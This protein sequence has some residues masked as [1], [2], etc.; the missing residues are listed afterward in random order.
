MKFKRTITVILAAVMIIALASCNTAGSQYSDK[1]AY[2]SIY[3]YGNNNK[4]LL[5]SEAIRVAPIDETELVE[6]TT[7]GGL[8]TEEYARQLYRLTPTPMYALELAVRA[9]D[10]NAELPQVIVSQFNGEVEYTL[11]T[12]M[13]N[14]AG[15]AS[16]S[17][18]IYEWQCKINGEVVD[19]F[20]TK[21]NTYDSVVIALVEKTYRSFNVA[22]EINNGEV[23]I[24]PEKNFSALGEKSELT[25]SKY[26]Q[27][28]YQNEKGE[29]VETVMSALGITLSEDGKRV[30]KIGNLEND[31]E[32]RWICYYYD[33]EEED[34]IIND[35]TEEMISERKTISFDYREI[36]SEDT[37]EETAAEPAE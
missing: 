6:E 3:V 37:G 1:N 25:I 29:D 34:E 30:V 33:E 18:D 5:S 19:A 28:V 13:N 20:K 36:Q 10:K 4:T 31:E 21:L 15:K 23:T 35:L 16:G 14:T 27:T 2:V 26:L 32:H 7:E 24:T 8:W 22:F 11:D 9:K 12:V 17:N